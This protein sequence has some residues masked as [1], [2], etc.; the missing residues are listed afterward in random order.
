MHKTSRN[1]QQTMAS[2]SPLSFLSAAFPISTCSTP[3]KFPPSPKRCQPFKHSHRKPAHHH[4]S[5]PNNNPTTNSSE[6]SKAE[7]IVGSRRDVLIG[8]GG[9]C[10]AAALSSGNNH[11]AVAA[12]VPPPNME[13]CLPIH[14]SISLHSTLPNQPT[15]PPTT[16]P[17]FFPQLPDNCCP[18]ISSTT[19]IIDFEFPP[20]HIPFRVRPAAHS[21]NGDYIAKY[22]E[23]VRLMKAL[24]TDDPRN[25]IQQANVH[26]AYCEGFYDQLGFPGVKLQVHCSWLFFPFHRWYLY[27]YERI[28]GSL[29]G[30]PNFA[31]PFWNWDNPR[32]G[33][34]IPSIYTDTNSPLFDPNRDSHHQPP[35][36]IDL[37]HNQSS[38]PKARNDIINDNLITMYK[39]VV[40]LGKLP[41]LFLGSPYRAGC[42][43]NPGAGSL[44]QKPHNIVHNWT[45]DET[46]PHNQDMGNFYTAGRDPIF[47]AHHANVDRMWNIWKTKVPCGK[48]RDF[49]DPDWLESSFLFY[50]EDANLVRVKVKDCL[51][52]TRLGYA[53]QEVDIPWLNY[54]PKPKHPQPSVLRLE[55]P[56]QIPFILDSTKRIVL[57]RPLKMVQSLTEAEEV[58]VID[59]DCAGST[60]GKKF[61]VFINDQYDDMI[62]PNHT[63]F[64]GSFVSLP[65]L[66]DDGRNKIEC[67]PLRLGITELLEDLKA[68]N[69]KTILV[70]LVPRYGDNVRITGVNIE[71]VTE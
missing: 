40:S 37:D 45:G 70:T 47:F 46:L 57:E 67:C 64:A 36:L 23:A 62:G 28:L 68:Q 16:K 41:S 60:G 4:I 69:D 33:M 12:P 50:D 53:F 65:H 39:Q 35:T 56:V 63:E 20:P 48:R 9:L 59:I 26:C 1:N 66:H 27:F 11:S 24:P 8:L 5:N 6:E 2:T 31:L 71:L 32:G 15:I 44:E 58:L 18:P 22:E 29:I 54:G 17:M 61:D 3:S 10:G 13:T 43:P 25:F 55:P 14:P 49:T 7:H 21:V 30:D 19:S 42:P 38:Y 52:T 34:T 51:D